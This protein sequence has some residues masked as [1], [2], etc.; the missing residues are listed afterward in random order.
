MMEK[1]NTIGIY[2]VNPMEILEFHIT[3]K[4]T[5]IYNCTL[6]TKLLNVLFVLVIHLQVRAKT[7]PNTLRYEN[8]W[9]FNVVVIQ[10]D[11]NK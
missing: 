8:R 1:L 11:I 5:I 3:K 9:Q 7:G 6:A 10:S 2:F 4:N